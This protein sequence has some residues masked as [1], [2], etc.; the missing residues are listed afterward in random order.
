[1][2]TAV[3]ITVKIDDDSPKGVTFPLDE[4]IKGLVTSLAA[5][6]CGTCAVQQE[7][8]VTGSGFW[9]WPALS[10]CECDIQD[11]CVF[12]FVQGARSA[13]ARGRTR[14]RARRAACG[15]ERS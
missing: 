11:G 7:R 5:C 8:A 13:A 1:M 15:L 10:L 9:L 4:T 6:G 2:R 3:S 14:T 12:L